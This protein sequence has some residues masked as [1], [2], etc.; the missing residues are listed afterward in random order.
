MHRERNAREL[1][2]RDR[3]TPESDRGHDD[4]DAR[5][6]RQTGIHHR[7]ALINA[8]AQRGHD[9][10]DDPQHVRIVVEHAVGAPQPTRLLGE[11]LAGRVDHHLGDRRIVQ[12][13]LHRTIAEELIHHLRQEDGAQ[14]GHHLDAILGQGRQHRLLGAPLYLVTIRSGARGRAQSL[15]IH[16]L[17]HALVYLGPQREHMLW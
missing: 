9:L 13:W 7:R 16:L 4:V 3:R 14:A 15:R 2:D 5:A 10:V 1:A 8:P 17:K 6:I 12:Q 11:D